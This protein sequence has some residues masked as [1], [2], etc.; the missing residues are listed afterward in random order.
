MT[1]MTELQKGFAKLI[2]LLSLFASQDLFAQ[3]D[4]KNTTQITTQSVGM[5][6]GFTR[7]NLSSKAVYFTFGGPGLRYKRSKMTYFLGLLPSIRMRDDE[8]IPSVGGGFQMVYKQIALTFPS[9]Y[10]AKGKWEFATGLGVVFPLK[11]TRKQ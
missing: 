6:N 10:Y 11:T 5:L 3:D 8:A 1:E 2:V 7:V 9:F 4:I